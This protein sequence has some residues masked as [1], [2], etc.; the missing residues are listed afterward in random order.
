MG[1][2]NGS[3]RFS[4]W[5][6]DDLEVTSGA[7]YPSEGT[8]GTEIEVTGNNF[9]VKKGKVLIGSTS[10]KVLDWNTES[11]IKSLLNK[12]IEP[13]I[14]NVTIQ[15]KEGD[16][17][18][19]EDAFILRPPEIHAIEQGEGTAYDE[20]TIRGKFFG[21]KKGKVYLEY[22][23]EGQIVRKSCKVT[24]WWM[25]P[26]TNESEIFFIVPKMLPDVFD[27]VVDPYRTIPEIEEKEGFTVKT[28]EIEKVDPGS[29]WVGDP[30]TI[31]GKYFGSKKGKVY[32]GYV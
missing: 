18:I 23:E 12:I 8:Y 32:L 31:S 14:Y 16:P 4:G 17:I 7:L 3:R 19:Y 9:G 26:V 15:P 29:G 30:I 13:G 20:I 11:S 5:N 22:E 2:T 6:I 1:P 10:L 21:T 24:K 28:P 27:V 25:D